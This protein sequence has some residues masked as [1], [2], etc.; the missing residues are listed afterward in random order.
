MRWGLVKNISDKKIIVVR[1][2]LVIKLFSVV[3]VDDIVVVVVVVA[4]VIVVV[5]VGA[6]CKL[7]IWN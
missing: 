7:N 1:L 3:V 2:K 4:T 5:R 6:N